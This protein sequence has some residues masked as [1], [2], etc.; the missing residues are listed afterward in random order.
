MV[1]PLPTPLSRRDETTAP[2]AATDSGERHALVTD[3]D[4]IGRKVAAQRLSMKLSSCLSVD[5]EVAKGTG[6]IHALAG[7]RLDTDK[8]YYSSQTGHN[9]RMHLR[10]LDTLAEG[11]DFLI[12]H[13][14]INFDLERLRAVQPDLRLLRLPVVDTLW[15][16]PLAF[17]RHPYHRLV[18]HYREGDLKRDTRNDPELDARL[19]LGAFQKQQEAL[20]N[21]EPSLLAAW[22]WLCT[23]P[24]HPGFNL[25]FEALRR[26]PRPSEAGGRNA[27]EERLQDVACVSQARR[28]IES[29]TGHGW[30]LAYAL[31]WL[32]VSGGNSVMPPWV[33]HQFPEAGRLTRLLRDTA[34]TD[35]ACR[36]CRQRHD[37]RDEL[38][39][40]FGFDGYR[41]MPADEHGH[42]LQQ[43]IVEAAMAGEHVLGILPTSTGK[44]ICY[45]VPALSRYDKTGALTVVISPLVALMADQVAGLEA[46]G[47][48]SCV[49]ISGMLSM[50]ERADALERLRLGDA[51]IVL[52]SPEQLRS[53]SLRRALDQREIGAWVLDEA[54]CLSKWGHDFRPDY[55]YVGRFIRESAQDGA[56]PPVLCLT[57]TA[58]PD[59]KSEIVDYFREQ[60]GVEMRVF[61]GG[62]ERT[63][64][65]FEVKP[66][67]EATKLHD[68]QLLLEQHLSSETK[69]GAIVYCA[70][71]RHTE[72]VAGFLAEKGLSADRFHAR[73]Q[74]EEKKNIQRRFI[75]GELQVIAAT[76][77]FGMGI[78]K[79]DVRLVVHADIPSSLENYLQ[80]AGRAG[81]DQ[82]NAYCVL[83]YT[84]DDIDR[85]FTMS[86]RSRLTR[87]EIHSVLRALRR[88]RGR[89]KGSDDEFAASV[90]EILAED[91]EHEFR[92]NA[93]TDDTRARTAVMWLEDAQLLNRDE[94]KVRVF[95]SS[96]R[97]Q[98]VA[99]ARRQLDSVRMTDHERRPLIRIVAAL[100]ESDPDA[101]ISTDHLMTVAG[102]DSRGVRRALWQLEQHGVASDDTAITAFVHHGVMNSSR[103]R[104]D[105][106]SAVERDLLDWMRELV[107]DLDVGEEAPL[108]LRVASQRL[109][110]EGHMDVRPGHVTRILR[111]VARDGHAEGGGSGSLTLRT[112]HAESVAV[113]LKREWS[114]LCS[115]ADKRR[116]GASRL[117]TLLLSKL[118]KGQQGNDILVETTLGE[119]TR[120][121]S[122]DLDLAART[123]DARELMER[124]LLW[125]HEQEVIRLNKGLTVF[126]SAMTIRLAPGSR[127]FTKEDFESLQLHYEE[128]TRQ[129]HVMAEYAEKGLR[130][131][132]DAIG[133]SLDY[134]ALG[135][136]EFLRRWLPD[137]RHEI[138]RQT[139]PESWSTIVESLKNPVQRQLVVDDR[140]QTNVLVL[141]GPGSGKTRVLVHRIA[142]LV[143]V[144]REDPRGILALAYNRHAA[145]EIRRRLAELIG[146]DSRG[147]T[148]LTCHA[149]AMR[150]VGASFSGTAERLHK[151]DFKDRLDR[152]LDDAA[153][154]L[155]GEGLEPAEAEEARE[156]LLARLRWILVDEYQDINGGQ[157][158]LISA[159]AGRTLLEPDA[160][161]SLFAVGDDD[162][163]IYSFNEASVEYIRRFEAHY[164]AKPAYLLDNYR[165]TGHIIDAANA[166]IVEARQRMKA[167]HPIRVNR[168]RTQEPA[169]GE[170][171]DLDAVGGGRVQVLQARNGPIHQAQA[172]LAELRRLSSLDA[173]WDWS[174]CAVIA[175]EWRYLDPVRSLCEREGIQTQMARDDTLSVW[176]LRETQALVARLRESQPALMRNSDVRRWLDGQADGPWI[177][178][179]DQ[180]AQEH[181]EEAGDAETPVA[182]FL[183]WLAEWSRDARRR[184]RGLLLTSAHKAK[185]LE[186][187]HAAVLDGGWERS[188][189]DEDPDE[190]RRLY[191]VAMT[192]AR[193]TLTL[194]SVGESNPYIKLLQDH[195]SV[196]RREPVTLPEPLP[197]AHQTYR[198]LGLGDVFISFAGNKAPWDR[199]H[200]AIAALAPGEPLK[201]RSEAQPWELANQ[202][203]IV[204]CRLAEGFKPPEGMRCIRATVYAVVVRR[205]EQS[206]PEYQEKL[207][208]DQWEVIVPELVFEPIS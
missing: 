184:Q 150:L 45:Q 192:R 147:V 162:Q 197:E 110:D 7:V 44:S 142:Y 88:L 27:V 62:S 93:A 168:A 87:R 74:P 127:R 113:T 30:S 6:R 1:T 52:C 166:V 89:N 28:V 188:G 149:L 203:G 112:L 2:A 136:E 141:A 161:L 120:A 16:N 116:S 22:H 26:S 178:L 25:F 66:T 33:R 156:R 126:R 115:L 138:K 121:I 64:L 10:A 94:N 76:N 84:R 202:R 174:R 3:D 68:I 61:D 183:E 32:S 48:T 130:S 56:T 128:S 160:R 77:A 119:L 189:N 165:S 124:A 157:Y 41:P 51:A 187:D 104:L 103:K 11:A 53:V 114:S 177:E 133:L 208:C 137:K 107:P 63:N 109:R 97:V 108:D 85:Q 49:A 36:W 8:T 59:V 20:L 34:C 164:K 73:L 23:G 158:G 180:A 132:A 92:R 50:P 169:G 65:E 170:W 176:Q 39:R 70:T 19:A 206:G 140:E 15:L 205:R 12:G 163:N 182:S 159:L 17:P 96:L 154:L 72:M 38:K 179:L 4:A 43:A 129:V 98:S 99:E 81:R 186:F 13:N 190:S 95:A 18:K 118:R 207:R 122:D 204:V 75:D 191:Y 67:S 55:R 78:D 153:E 31:A 60:L 144:R 69:G 151:E 131:M 40:F 135:E 198:R 102:L 35:P 143:R 71:R 90:G 24:E 134:F 172:A 167:N 195:E 14:L 79:P 200:A 29:G 21:V 117:L 175:R 106:A 5:L 123:T 155:R 105:Q 125:L 101:G 47:I 100:I 57:A 171:A 173:R 196:L 86:A 9:L 146:D 58:K 181:E 82:Q 91:E 201:I 37:A 139:T 111:G 42:P 193:L 199:T 46:K 83:L 185:G 54:H 194:T 152:V 148:V 80:E 145:A